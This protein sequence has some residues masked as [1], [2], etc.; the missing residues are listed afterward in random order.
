MKN[1]KIIGYYTIPRHDFGLAGS[2]L[3][4]IEN[5]VDKKILT[6]Y[7]FPK[8][9][10]KILE[11]MLDSEVKTNERKVKQLSKTRRGNYFSFA[12]WLPCYGFYIAQKL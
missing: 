4:L 11:I 2:L 6:K 1:L 5:T 7:T 3:D 8:V 9:K 12:F 10:S